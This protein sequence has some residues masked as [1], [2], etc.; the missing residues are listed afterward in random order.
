MLKNLIFFARFFLFWLLFF[1]L[2][3]IIFLGANLHNLATRP[4]AEILAAGYH[5]LQLDLSMAAYIAAVPLLVFITVLL[6][7][8]QKPLRANW[9]KVYHKV[10]VVLFSIIVVANLNIYREWGSKINAKA[11]GFAIHT[12][13]EA[14]ASSASSPIFLNICILAILLISGLWLNKKIIKDNIIITPA[15]FSLK[16]LFAVL[17]LGVNFLMI[18]GGWG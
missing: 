3:R 1:L 11:L 2:E 8:R 4:F 6:F 16:L 17:L 5:G 7:N 9:L 13:N 15:P 12:P 18:R 14:L 10:L